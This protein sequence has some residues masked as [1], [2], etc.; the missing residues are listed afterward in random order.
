MKVILH[1]SSAAE[2]YSFS[3]TNEDGGSIVRSE[4]YKDK[5]G[6]LGGIESVRKNSADDK[7]YEA[8]TSSNGKYYFNIKSTNGQV[9]ATS[10]MHASEAD[11]AAAMQRLKT[12]GA[13]AE[14][15]DQT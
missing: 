12:Q 10:P 11:R 13:S 15:D 6:A 2:P 3:F 4:N 7:R 14:L 9:V 1:K 5:K 8:K